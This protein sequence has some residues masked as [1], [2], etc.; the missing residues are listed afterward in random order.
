MIKIIIKKSRMFILLQQL[1]E[2]VELS[3]VHYI[4]LQGDMI[5]SSGYSK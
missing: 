5:V 1:F 3:T 4:P 2:T